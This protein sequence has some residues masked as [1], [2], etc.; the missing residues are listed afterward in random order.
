[1]AHLDLG[2]IDA[3]AGRQADA[4][5]EVT[6][7]EKLA[8]NDVNVHWRLGRLYRAMRNQQKAKAEFDKAKSITETAD[9]ALA[10]KINPHSVEAPV[11]VP[12][13]GSK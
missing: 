5:R 11:P 2:V 8:P 13:Q 10:N 6:A 7:A 9:S 12:A 3:D 4:L 1:L